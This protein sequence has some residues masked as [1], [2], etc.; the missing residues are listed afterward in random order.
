MAKLILTLLFI[1]GLF[2][3][4]RRTKFSNDQFLDYP[5]S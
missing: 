2:F 1:T 3:I 4:Y 5:P